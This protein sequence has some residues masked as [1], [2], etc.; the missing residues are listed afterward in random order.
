[1]TTYSEQETEDLLDE[2]LIE[3]EDEGSLSNGSSE[4]SK[5]GSSDDAKEHDSEKWKCNLC[6]T[7]YKSLNDLRRHKNSSIH[8]PLKR[9]NKCKKIEKPLAS[10]TK[11]FFVFHSC[12]IN[13]SSN[14]DDQ[15]FCLT[16][17]LCL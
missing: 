16:K 6:Q 2:L 7:V 10:I 8:N 12:S 17:M 5:Q 9:L 1:M 3:L 14:I 13:K 15:I 4:V 11:L